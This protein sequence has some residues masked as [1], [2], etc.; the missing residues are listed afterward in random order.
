[1]EKVLLKIC[2]EIHNFSP[3][4]NA[5]L[6]GGCVRDLLLNIR[7]NDFDIEVFNVLPNDLQKI[8]SKHFELDLVGK[9]FG[10]IKLRDYPI[11]IS[12]PRRE[13]KRGEGHKGFLVDSD[14]SISLSSACIRR[15]LTINSMAMDLQTG[16]LFDF[17]RGQK[18]LKDKILR[19][20]S[21][22]FKDDPLRVL[23]AMQFLARF[24]FDPAP[25]LIQISKEVSI[26]GLS[27]ERIWEEWKKFIVKGMVP[28]KGLKF[29]RDCG[30][31]NYFPELAVLESIEQDE[32]WHKEGNVLIHTMMVM[33][34][35]AKQKTGNSEE[36]LIVGLGCLCHDFGKAI[37]AQLGEE[38]HRHPELGIGS[39]TSFLQKM[40]NQQDLIDQVVNLVQYHMSPILLFSSK[41]KVGNSAIRRLATKTNIS[42]LARVAEAD[43]LGRGDPNL[44]EAKC[45][46]WLIDRASNLKVEK[47]G[48]DPIIM[49]RHLIKLGFKQG[50]ELGKILKVLYN[51]QLDGEFETVEDGLRLLTLP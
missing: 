8:L 37:T 32:K 46:E 5:Y 20:T 17:F 49:G 34:E 11:D 18:D 29:L 33:D 12:I 25:E 45:G 23:R 31:I 2:N 19:P 10:V 48:P 41:G 3:K 39:A 51:A 9:D 26:E 14:P 22:A 21:E 43:Q 24:G 27:S 7:P 6:V 38:S 1:M 30:W 42:R 16:K 50:P 13:W 44:E 36:D 35:F 28:S 15:D 40:T 47:K 4:A